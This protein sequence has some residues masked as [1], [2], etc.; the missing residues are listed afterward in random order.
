MIYV[1]KTGALIERLG[2]E[3]AEPLLLALVRSIIF[4]WR[5][6]H[7]PEF[8]AYTA[9]LRDWG[10]DA[11][12]IVPNPS[13]I[14]GLNAKQAM[15]RLAGGALAPPESLFTP[16]LT[17]NSQ[18]LLT[19]DMRYQEQTNGK[20]ADNVGWLSFTHALT[21][22]NAVRRQCTKYPALWPA[23]LLQLAC[24]SGRNAAYTDAKINSDAWRVDDRAAF[25]E[26]AVHNLFD[27]A[28]EEFIVSVHLLKTVL[29]ARDEATA[30]TSEAAAL[31]AAA[32]N[33]FL[34]SPL[35]RKHVRRT[36]RQALDFVALDG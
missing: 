4:A 17:V 3:C 35:K 30:A 25:F 9:I 10:K 29:A 7:L 16:L 21:F 8:R 23:G 2:Q 28:K 22:A 6:D 13:E 14:A 26:T 27:H 34:S 32:M 5:E 36:A 19:Y 15:R 18:N 33:R 20:I 12:D 11:T 24:F 31:I 1:P